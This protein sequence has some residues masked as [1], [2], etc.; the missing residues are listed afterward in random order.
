[1]TT[2]TSQSY[3]TLVAQSLSIYCFV[4]VLSLS[5]PPDVSHF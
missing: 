5:L 3:R 1:M 4:Q 2:L